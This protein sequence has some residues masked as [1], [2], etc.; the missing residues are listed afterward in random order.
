MML[1][2]GFALLPCLAQAQSFPTNDA[3]W[4]GV[5]NSF[6]GPVPMRQVMC[7]DTTINGVQ[8][9]RFYNYANIPGVGDTLLYEL[10][11]RTEGERVWY[12]YMEQSQER[13][14]YD[15][16]LQA[17]EE[18][19]LNYVGLND[20]VTLQVD[21]VVTMGQGSDTYRVICFKP[22]NGIIESWIQGVGST[23]G[24]INRG[25]IAIDALGQ[26]QCYRKSGEL[27]YH[28][29]DDPACDFEYSCQLTDVE[30]EPNAEAAL[31][32]FPTI[33][34]GALQFSNPLS[35]PVVLR[36][37]NIQGQ[38][39]GQYGPFEKGEHMLNTGELSPGM[40]LFQA[41]ETNKN[42]SLQHFKILITRD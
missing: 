40:Y 27:L 30:P 29:D 34:S 23:L 5:L 13:L 14:L 21:S 17:G 26:L 6:I 11:I 42:L 10:A 32:L 7:G 12:V 24:P 36:A 22:R 38:L 41:V 8:Y 3:T 19:T 25:L 2:L 37:F 33:S 9:A 20:E 28:S 39:T 16:S 15:F 4:Q 31:K 1:Y 18:I 35:M